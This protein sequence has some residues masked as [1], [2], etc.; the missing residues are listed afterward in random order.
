MTQEKKF[1]FVVFKS[2]RRLILSTS[3]AGTGNSGENIILDSK[4]TTDYY[5]CHGTE[6]EVSK[7]TNERMA[8]G[9][10]FDDYYNPAPNFNP[11][12]HSDVLVY[13]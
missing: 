1:I 3:E 5:L 2:P 4:R 7:W 8:E 11:L 9:F 13:L 12:D 10:D 6:A